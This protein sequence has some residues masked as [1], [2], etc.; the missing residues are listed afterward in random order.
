MR[1][2]SSL[3]FATFLLLAPAWAQKATVPLPKPSGFNVFSVDQEIEVG[4]QNAA[5]VA[6]QYPLLPDS[7]P[8]VQY[9]QHLGRQLTQQLPQP[10]YPFQFHVIAQKEVNAFA[11]PGGPVYV[12]LGTIQACSNEAQLAGVMAHEISHVYMRHST[13]EATKKLVPELGLGAAGVLFGGSVGGQLAQLGGQFVIGSA[14]LKYSRNAESQ[15]DH[16]GAQI[17]YDAGYDPYQ[18]ALFFAKLDEEGGSRGSQ[19]FSDH[20]NPGN[21]SQAIRTEIAQFPPKQ[22]TDSSADFAR[23]HQ[24]AMSERTYSAQEVKSGHSG[25]G[26]GG[27]GGDETSGGGGRR[28]GR[29]Q[30][31]DEDQDQDEGSD[32]RGPDRDTSDHGGPARGGSASAPSGNFQNFAH[33][34]YTIRYPDNWQLHGD[35]QSA[36]TIAPD[37]GIAHDAVAYGAIINKFRPQNANS[38]DQSTQQLVETLQQSNPAL[39]AIGSPQQITVNNVHGLSQDFNGL[40]PLADQNGQQERERDWLVAL[41]SKDGSVMYVIFIAPDQDFINLRPTFQQMLRTFHLK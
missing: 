4:R 11:L 38:I 29:D 32:R 39:K 24:L 18:L 26:G 33:T 27:R 1:Q 23:I 3:F 8:I 17:M 16:V 21:R 19:F 7:S 36:V 9:V 22:F 35:P 25:S 28:G 20:P 34:D 37:N 40:S 2:I 13:N 41:P 10:T 15:A 14:F 30:D 5:Q 31:P 6:R 12:N